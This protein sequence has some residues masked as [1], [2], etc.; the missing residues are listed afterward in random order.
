[1]FHRKKPIPPPLNPVIPKAQE[2][3]DPYNIQLPYALADQPRVFLY[4]L[5][6]NTRIDD[7]AKAL[8]S[9]WLDKYDVALSEHLLGNY[10]FP[11]W[12]QANEISA[13]VS[14]QFYA[15]ARGA[16]DAAEHDLFNFLEGD[17]DGNVDPA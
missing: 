10:G 17:L 14:A 6:K 16:V 15:A 3:A 13:H 5:A 11:G 2:T 7:D 1:M 9:E 4:F 12:F 8:I